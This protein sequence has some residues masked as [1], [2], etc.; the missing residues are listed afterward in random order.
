MP[1]G[2]NFS[3]DNSDHHAKPPRGVHLTLE[4]IAAADD[5]LAPRLLGTGAAP[6]PSWLI[7]N[8]RALPRSV[9]SKMTGYD[10]H[11]AYRIP[12]QELLGT[13]APAVDLIAVHAKN[14]NVDTIAVFDAEGKQLHLVSHGQYN[15]FN[16]FEFDLMVREKPI[17][18]VFGTPPATTGNALSIR[19]ANKDG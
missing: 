5:A 6:N 18:V 3:I 16:K 15:D 8:E 4:Q 19:A 11:A 13:G 14:A 10:S 12:L 1:V 2:T 9:K 7:T 17:K